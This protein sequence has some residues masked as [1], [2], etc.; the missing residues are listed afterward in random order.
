[1][2][3]LSEPK[4]GILTLKY[5]P[6]NTEVTENPPRF[7]WMPCN[8]ENGPYTIEISNHEDFKNIVYRCEAIPQNYFAPD[9]ALAEGKYFWRFTITGGE[10]DYSSVRTFEITAGIPKTPVGNKNIRLNNMNMAHPRLWLTAD[11]LK[12][13]RKELAK[14]P[15]YCK[16][17]VFIEKTAKRY[18]D[19]PIPAEPLPYPS[20]KR[21]I[22]HWRA[23][24]S[25]CQEMFNYIRFVSIAGVVTENEDWIKQAVAATLAA[26]R[27]D[28]DGTTSRHYNDECGFRMAGMLAWGFDWLYNYMTEEERSEVKDVLVYRT[29][30]V[31]HHAFVSS[32]IHYSLY[33][34]HAVRSIPSVMV[35]CAL[36][37]HGEH[38]KATD[39]LHR[40]INYLNVLYTPWGGKDGGWSE[41]SMYWTTGMAF[42]LEGV[43]LLKNATGIDILK[44]PFFQHTADFPIYCNAHDTYRA[45]FC[46]QSSLGNK[47]IL[48]TGFNARDLAGATGNGVAQWYFEQIA[49]RESYDDPSF[50]NVGWWDFYFNE[51]FYLSNYGNIKATP[52]KSGRNCKWFK[53]V[54]WVALHANMDDEANHI[55]LL[56][57][58]S[59]YGS[60]SHSHG[61][62]N[63]ITLTAFGDT[64]LAETGYYI[65]FF[66]SMHKDW[67]K[68][69]RAH[70]LITINGKSQYAGFDKTV[71]LAA[72]GV[73][74]SMTEHENYVHV[75]EDAT[76]G[77]LPNVPTLKSYKREI[78]FIDNEYFV[79]VDSVELT[80][81]G[82]VGFH[83]H[84][85]FEPEIDGERVTFTG[86]NAKLD[87]EVVL[88]TAGVKDYYKTDDF[89]GVDEK[90]YAD[91]GK[92]WHYNMSTR[93]AKN[94]VIVT[95]LTP[96]KTAEYKEIG[97]IK[98]DQGHD[99]F[100]YFTNDGKTFPLVIDGN[101][102]Y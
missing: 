19:H 36:A 84:S 39:W 16:F 18:I 89:E 79:I 9:V 71:Q 5:L 11:T 12:N 64:L 88:A 35:P 57:K 8:R 78:Y 52:P 34:S 90:E 6:D 70:N 20:G 30:D 54:G 95:C 92:Q 29:T 45:S 26:A 55:C 67:R 86:P 4:S 101:K 13:F 98:D 23:S 80:E 41:G 3:K 38:E 32:K 93:E 48:K 82:Y 72:V 46:D 44:R 42:M 53:D 15:S 7:S 69:S 99:I 47:A 2:R 96:S 68:Q 14:D 77:Y 1:M 63:A 40:T 33:D 10:F 50:F 97:T 83:L 28:K 43:N 66:A 73:V 25:T 87:A 58:S 37:L 27:W 24:Y 60:V 49:K 62:Q 100:L 59:P 65:G 85:M 75:V 81:P 51:T 31:E 17:D 91:L 94:H 22:L 76:A 61:D 21:E 74:E 102:R 56:T